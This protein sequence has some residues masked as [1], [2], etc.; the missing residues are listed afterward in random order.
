MDMS[1]LAVPEN[2]TYLKHKS[3]QI[4]ST[5]LYIKFE[6]TMFNRILTTRQLLCMN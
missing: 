5:V 3:I 2:F 6:Q 4:R 1:C